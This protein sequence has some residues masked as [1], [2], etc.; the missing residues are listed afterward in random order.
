MYIPGGHGISREERNDTDLVHRIR[1]FLTLYRAQSEKSLDLNYRQNSE[2]SQMTLLP[3]KQVAI[4][5]LDQSKL[6]WRKKEGAT[7]ISELTKWPED[8]PFLRESRND[9][10][11]QYTAYGDVVKFIQGG[12]GDLRHIGVK[13]GEVVAYAAPP[14]G[15]AAAALAFLTI[16]AQTVAAPIAPNTSEA[17]TLDTLDQFH[18]KHM[19]LFEGVS[20]PGVE[21]GFKKYEEMGNAKLHKATIL[22]KDKPGMFEFIVSDNTVNKKLSEKPLKN[23]EGGTCLLL[24]TSGTTARPKG[25]PLRQEALV[26]NGAILAASMQLREDGKSLSRYFATSD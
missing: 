18:A 17:D 15:S 16:G 22:G 1:D 20:C 4:I 10:A 21:A 5:K 9:N 25:V 14:G 8:K 7:I 24:R 3:H 6:P 13:P 19:I 12:Q 26:V 11:S 2:V 23:E